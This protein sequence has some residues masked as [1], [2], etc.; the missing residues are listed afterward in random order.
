MIFWLNVDAGDCVKFAKET[1]SNAFA[2]NSFDCLV[3]E[4]ENN[5]KQKATDGRL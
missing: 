3:E 5:H 2:T 4:E 1:E